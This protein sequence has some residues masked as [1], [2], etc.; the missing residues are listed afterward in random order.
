MSAPRGSRPKVK[1]GI[2]LDPELYEWIVARTEIGGEFASVS[3]AIERC[4]VFYR[5][6]IENAQDA[7]EE[8]PEPHTT[9]ERAVR[10]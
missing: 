8:E 7:P 3:H 10:T 4:L 9:R 1:I 2:S 5:R 6:S